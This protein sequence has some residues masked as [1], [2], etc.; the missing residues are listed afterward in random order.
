MP[1]EVIGAGQG[2]AGTMALKNTR[3][4]QPDPK[5]SGEPEMT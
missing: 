4:N 2:D 3:S 1:L 5:T